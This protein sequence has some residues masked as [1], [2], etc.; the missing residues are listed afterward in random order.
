M[1][2]RLIDEQNMWPHHKLACN[3]DPPPLASRKPLCE[4]VS[5]NEFVS[6]VDMAAIASS[7]NDLL[8]EK[9][10]GSCKSAE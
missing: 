8:E 3:A 6:I 4:A 5:T 10:L 7:T 2:Q 1:V 9:T